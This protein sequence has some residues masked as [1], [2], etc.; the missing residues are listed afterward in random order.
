VQFRIFNIAYCEHYSLF[1]IGSCFP[2]GKEAGKHTAQNFYGFTVRC[3]NGNV[4]WKKQALI[5]ATDYF[6]ALVSGY[7]MENKDSHVH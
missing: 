1:V 7:F 2:E 6:R 4:R 5:K 3:S